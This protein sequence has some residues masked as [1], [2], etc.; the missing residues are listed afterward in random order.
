MSAKFKNKANPTLT[1]LPK[2]DYQRNGITMYCGDCL[3]LLP[4]FEDKSVDAVV[5]DP[6]YNEVNRKTGGLREIDKGVADSAVVEPAILAKEISRI[7]SGTA[8]VWCGTEQVSIWRFEFV[9]NRMTTRQC[10]WEKT[11]PSPMN[12][13]MLWLSSLELCVFARKP[14]ATFNRFYES[15]VWRG[16]S[17]RISEHPTEKPL[18]LIENQTDASTNFGDTILD[19]F[20]GSGTTGV[21]CIRTGR[22]FIGIEK[23]P[24]YFDIAVKRIEAEFEKTALLDN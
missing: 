13:Q 23:E 16:P 8:Y 10:V 6:P 5:T 22:K 2:P 4:L 7:V 19:P 21:A 17:K 14:K 12:A 9:K 3:E 24:K 1:K 20:M 11:N 18:W 15:P